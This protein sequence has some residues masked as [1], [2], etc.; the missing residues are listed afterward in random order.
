MLYCNNL[1]LFL[2]LWLKIEKIHCALEFDQSKWLKPYI[3][4]NA[5]ERVEAGKIG[6]KGGKQ[7]MNNAVYRKTVDNLK[8]RFYIKWV[9]KEKYYLKWISK[10]CYVVQKIFDNDL[11]AIHKIKTTLTVNKPDMLEC[12]Y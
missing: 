7:L 3:K 8:S 6:Y 1:Q 2:W 12:V 4:F 10:P 9:I 5:Q 11:A